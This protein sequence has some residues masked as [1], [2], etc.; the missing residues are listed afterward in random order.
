VTSDDVI[1]TIELIK[2]SA[3]LF[4]Q[5]VKDLWSQIEVKELDE[6]TLQFRLPEPFA[7]FLDYA[8]FGILPRH[9][10]GDVPVDQFD[11]A[12]FN[13]A[14]VGTGPYRFEELLISGGR[15][16]GVVLNA[17]EDFYLA[18][19]FIDQ[20]VFR[21]YPDAASAFD[22]YQQGEVLGIS[23]VTQDVLE[24]ALMQEN[25]SVYTSRLPQMSLVFLNLNEPSLPFM[26]VANVRRALLLGI[27]RNNIVSRIL[28]GQAIVADAPILP[29]SWAYYDGNEHLD[30]DPDAAAALLKE[31][32]YVIPAVE[33]TCAPKKVK[34]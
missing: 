33:V 2:S 32:G 31:E 26:Q 28:N 15:I 4:P 24:D 25:L 21:F 20:V 6:H 18:R 30:Y 8:T 16:T 22:A 1:F 27:N 9:L 14:P 5:D 10:L 3:S 7:P 11:T 13:L 23:Q 34:P 12:D 19:P 17:N 29:G